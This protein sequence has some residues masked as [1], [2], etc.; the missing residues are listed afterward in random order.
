MLDNNLIFS[1]VTSLISTLLF[2]L[3][4][5]KSDNNE[6]KKNELLFLFGIIFMVTF[7]LKIFSQGDS[8]KISSG[9]SSLSHSS[10]PPF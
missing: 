4:T 9:E 8:I 3:F 10:R 7:I 6:N 5:N 2:Y 1:L